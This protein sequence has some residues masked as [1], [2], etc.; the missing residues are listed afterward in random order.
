MTKF[1]YLQQTRSTQLANTAEEACNTGLAT[2]Y[3]KRLK[4]EKGPFGRDKYFIKRLPL[5]VLDFW[6]LLV[7][8]LECERGGATYQY[9]RVA[10]AAVLQLE[11]AGQGGVVGVA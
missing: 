7:V 11:A 4:R 1:S 5:Y 8:S 9:R 6:Q 10:H 2:N 3:Q